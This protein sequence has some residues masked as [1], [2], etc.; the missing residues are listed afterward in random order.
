MATEEQVQQMLNLM[1]QQMTQLQTLQVEN[2]QLRTQENTTAAQGR[3]MKTKA[4]E[5]PIVN[6]NTDEREWELLKTVGTDTKQ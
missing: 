2:T 1:Q 4:P 5:R 3:P 6:E